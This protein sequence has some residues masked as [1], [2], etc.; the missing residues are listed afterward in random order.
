MQSTPSSFKSLWLG[1][2]ITGTWSKF[3]TVWME[4]EFFWQW[5][6]PE[7]WRTLLLQ[8]P[9][10]A[11]LIDNYQHHLKTCSVLA[12]SYQFSMS[13]GVRCVNRRSQWI[14]WG[15]SK[16]TWCSFIYT[17]TVLWESRIKKISAHGRIPLQCWE[18]YHS[19]AWVR[20]NILV[21]IR[22]NNVG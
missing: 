9:T 4:A 13:F 6:N 3:L 15:P 7:R 19:K 18:V 5:M 17:C 20:W 11:I 2:S 22:W 8:S 21:N 16:P 12:I 10:S 1:A 14:Y